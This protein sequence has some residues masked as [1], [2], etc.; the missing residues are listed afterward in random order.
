MRKFILILAISASLIGCKKN[1][2][3][4]CK[5]STGVSGGSIGS[6]PKSEAEEQCKADEPDETCVL[7]TTN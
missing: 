7:S 2:Y 5:S 3:C 6:M 1:Y 4:E